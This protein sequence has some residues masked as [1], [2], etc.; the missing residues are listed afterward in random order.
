MRR[1]AR[2]LGLGVKEG[3]YWTELFQ[4]GSLGDGSVP[5]PGWC[6][7]V[8]RKRPVTGKPV[9]GGAPRSPYPGLGFLDRLHLS[10]RR[11]ERGRPELGWPSWL[12]RGMSLEELDLRLAALGF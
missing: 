3:A 1:L 5:Y 4:L 7:T 8:D 11:R 12:R 10:R 6:W 2:F 9:A